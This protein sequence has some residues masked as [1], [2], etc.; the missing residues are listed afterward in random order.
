MDDFPDM[1]NARLVGG[2]YDGFIWPVLR[3]WSGCT[4]NGAKYMEQPD[5]EV[6]GGRLF[7]Y[8][9]PDGNLQA[10]VSA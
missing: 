6:I 2:P 8:V 4:V 7:H 10:P 9:E 1:S 5:E 3:E